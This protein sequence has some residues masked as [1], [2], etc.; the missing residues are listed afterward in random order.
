M[1]LLLQAALP[2]IYVTVQQPA[3]GMPE[4]A[5]TLISAGIGALFGIISS[6]AMEYI[7][8]AVLHRKQER[9]VKEQLA[10]E[11]SDNL[12]SIEGFAR[13]LQE[14][15]RTP[16]PADGGAVLSMVSGGIALL[17]NYILD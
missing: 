13:M 16:T 2:P 3:G 5:K 14:I 8:P 9:I 6:L 12:S 4:W 15:R 17:G 10:A 1:L 7:K 11:V